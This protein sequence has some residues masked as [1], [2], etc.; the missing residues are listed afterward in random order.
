MS[1]YEDELKA[2]IESL[3]KKN[4]ELQEDNDILQLRLDEAKGII[5]SHNMNI[6]NKDEIK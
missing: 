2:E 3:K 4:R 1:T 6:Y 5:D